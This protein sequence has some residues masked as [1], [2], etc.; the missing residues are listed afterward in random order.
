MGLLRD[1]REWE[2]SLQEAVQTATPAELLRDW[3]FLLFQ[4]ELE[5]RAEELK[6]RRLENCQRDEALYEST[7]DEDLKAA[8]RQ[9][10][11]G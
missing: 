4:H 6:I 2:F 7:T 10:L 5:L 11:F 9:R 8:L 3:D 1:D